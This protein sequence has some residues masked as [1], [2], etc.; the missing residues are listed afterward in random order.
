MDTGEMSWSRS[1]CLGLDRI[2]EWGLWVT[3]RFLVCSAEWMAGWGGRA[4]RS[5]GLSSLRR[6]YPACSHL[7]SA[8]TEGEV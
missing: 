5:L 7:C 8:G 2:W 1:R 3:L 6:F 4:L